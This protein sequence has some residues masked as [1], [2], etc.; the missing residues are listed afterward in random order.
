METQSNFHQDYERQNEVRRGV[1]TQIMI[2]NA[3]PNRPDL[4]DEE[5]KTAKEAGQYNNLYTKLEFPRTTK[6]HIDPSIPQQTYCLVSFI[7]WFIFKAFICFTYFFPYFII[8][9]KSFI[10]LKMD[11]I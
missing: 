5:L 4:T 8:I 10:A 2:A 3:D 7:C 1:Q 11:T 9:N 6:F